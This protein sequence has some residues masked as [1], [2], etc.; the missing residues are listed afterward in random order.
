MT[1]KK[2]GVEVSADNL[3]VFYEGHTDPA[4][5][6]VNF[7]VGRG[8]MAA[9][10]GPSGSGKSTLAKAILGLLPP[11]SGSV[12]LNDC[13]PREF[14][15]KNPGD[16][17]LVEQSTH[18]VTGTVS[19]NI[20]L[21]VPAQ[22]ID[23]DRV[24][25][26]LELAD[27]LDWVAQLPA[28]INSKLAPGETSGGQLQRLGLARAFYTQP[29]LLILDEPTSALDADTEK[30]ISLSLENLRGS[31]TRVVIAHRL[32]TIENADIV[33]VLEDGRITA[34]GSFDHLRKTNPL[35]ARQVEHLSFDETKSDP[36][37]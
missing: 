21:G 3:T 2:A 26:A 33:Y 28:G 23:P 6:S 17:S 37:S 25:R 35:V 5:N 10:I 8:Q 22:L 4:L 12:K 16:V 20:A 34:F 7:K 36:R 19:E 29:R 24:N 11:E 15:S 27:L 31:V 14:V 13:E 30:R 32:T 18:L 1:L 9:I